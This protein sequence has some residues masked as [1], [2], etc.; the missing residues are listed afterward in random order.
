M[1]QNVSCTVIQYTPSLTE[2]YISKT[3]RNLFKIRH[4]FQKDKC[5][6]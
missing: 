3:S 2:I 6:D 5:K 4:P 1:C